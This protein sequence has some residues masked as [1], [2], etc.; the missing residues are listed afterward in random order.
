MNIEPIGEKWSVIWDSP[1]TATEDLYWFLL[2]FAFNHCGV[3]G[4]VGVGYKPVVAEERG[5]IQYVS[6]QLW[7]QIPTDDAVA[8]KQFKHHLFNRL[9][10]YAEFNAIVFEREKE[11]VIFKEEI[12]RRQV[13]RELGGKAY[14]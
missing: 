8:E 6:L 10:E 13:W 2:R 7:E 5:F 1:D 12:E 14:W 9:Q 3:F 11:A 4:D